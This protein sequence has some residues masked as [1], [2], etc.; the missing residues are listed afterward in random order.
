MTLILN[1]FNSF[2]RRL[3]STYE[4]EN[5][6]F[7]PFL[8]VLVIHQNNNIK[9][10][11]Y[12]K[13][14]WSGRFLNFQSFN[15]VAQKKA[16]VKNLVDRA[17]DVS[18]KEFHETNLQ[19]IRNVLMFIDYQQ[20]FFEKIITDRY[21]TTHN[22]HNKYSYA[23]NF[24]FINKLVLPFSPELNTQIESQLKSYNISH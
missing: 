19:L 3:K 18:D 15:P 7:I 22:N 21:N 4:I 10:N 13:P 14:T 8:D 17:I 9:I 16:I 12:R 20:W 24:N 11:W 1:V 2:H 5:N 23:T 6:N